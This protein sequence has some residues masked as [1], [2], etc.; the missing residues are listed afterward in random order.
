[1]EFADE[2]VPIGEL[3][4]KRRHL[5]DV[6]YWMLGSAGEADGAVDETYRRWYALPRPEREAIDAPRAWLSWAV[7]AICLT[8]LTRL[9]RPGRRRRR[10][11]PDPDPGS[12]PDPDLTL[13]LPGART[14]V[15]AHAVNGRT[16]LVVRYG[17]RVA[18]VISLDIAGRHV[19]QVW[20][21]VNPDKLRRWNRSAP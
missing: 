14:T 18:A 15:D 10:A 16:G 20:V 2:A 17:Q 3:V 12:E 11:D 1:M 6:A 7:G 5:F 13:L 19:V 4:D 8:R 21:V 9:T